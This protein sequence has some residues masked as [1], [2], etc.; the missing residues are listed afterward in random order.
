[1]DGYAQDHKTVGFCVGKRVKTASTG[2][3]TDPP[4]DFL[5]CG[6]TESTTPNL[7]FKIK[8]LEVTS[9]DAS[10]YALVRA[11]FEGG[12]LIQLSRQFD[13]PD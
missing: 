8:T 3:R 13:S 9:M 1:M 5:G 12:I 4:R 7:R 11:F 2:V 10:N 6:L